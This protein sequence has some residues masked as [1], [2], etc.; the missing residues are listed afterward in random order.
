MC[1]TNSIV[2]MWN[3]SHELDHVHVTC[4]HIPTGIHYTYT[5]YPTTILLCGAFVENSWHIHY[6]PS[7]ASFVTHTLHTLQRV[8]RDTYTTYLKNA[9]FVTHTLPFLGRTTQEYGC[10]S[11]SVC[12]RE[13][14]THTLRTLQFLT[15]TLHTLP[16][17]Y[18]AV[19]SRL[20]L[21]MCMYM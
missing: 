8:V 6:I 14:V 13:F 17:C 15:R 1:V 10:R 21:C 12:V 5:T 2:Y 16:P 4:R 11:G 9:S 3:M 20:P 18:C 19:R 7:N